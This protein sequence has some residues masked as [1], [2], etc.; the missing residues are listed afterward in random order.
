M[1][2]VPLC[3]LV[4]PTT[5]CWLEKMEEASD[6][7]F[8]TR[9]GKAVA[10]KKG[11]KQVVATPVESAAEATSAAEPAEPRPSAERGSSAAKRKPRAKAAPAPAESAEPAAPEPAAPP[12][13][14]PAEPEPPEPE[15]PA[16]RAKPKP[17]PRAKKSAIREKPPEPLGI[18]LPEQPPPLERQPSTF[19]VMS[20]DDFGSL[21]NEYIS[22]RKSQGRDSRL[23]M[24]RSW[25]AT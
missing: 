22:S 15:P 14:P 18:E 24:Y 16:V 20:S 4:S 2:G 21:F 8:T 6:V 13:A 9:A 3:S 5:K 23:A 12:A 1:T 19:P 17:R 11:K 25:L 7:A 10:F